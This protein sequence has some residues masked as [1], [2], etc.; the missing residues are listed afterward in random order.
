MGRRWVWS[1]VTNTRKF[2]KYSDI[3]NICCNHSKIW[4]MLLCHRVM[5]PNDADGMATSADPDQTAPSFRSSLIWVCIVCPGISVRKLRIITVDKIAVHKSKTLIFGNHWQ[6]EE[7]KNSSQWSLVP[8][9][10]K[11]GVVV[12]LIDEMQV[13]PVF[14]YGAR[15]PPPE[16]FENQECRRSYLRPFCNAKLAHLVYL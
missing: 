3:Q 11:R 4:T 8:F 9:L 1:Q 2:P 12:G 6:I 7:N 13:F 14:L 10:T 16:N 15:G 5:S